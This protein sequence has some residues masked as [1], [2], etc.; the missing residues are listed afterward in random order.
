MT[1]AISFDRAVGYYDRTRALSPS[2]MTEIVELL[3]SEAR[4]PVLEIGVGTGLISLPLAER[5]LRVTGLDISN[6]MLR[7]LRAKGEMPV[8]LGDATRLPFATRSFG[9]AIAIRVFHLLP[10]WRQAASE[11]V[12][13]LDPGGRVLVCFGGYGGEWKTVMQAFADRAGARLHPDGLQDILDLDEHMESLG[14]TRRE[15]ATINDHREVTWERVVSDLEAGLY[16]W[17]WPVEASVR[18]R[19]AHA[20]RRW[21][22]SELGSLSE[23]REIF[24]ELPWVSYDVP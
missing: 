9:S 8:V 12:R 3:T 14:L 23:P 11:L 16:S 18:E 2:A 21:I 7:Q 19:A 15:L 10:N 13:V 4:E 24:L 1:D 17:T 20:T 6:E 5:G 22:E